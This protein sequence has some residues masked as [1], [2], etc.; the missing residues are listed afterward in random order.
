MN[1]NREITSTVSQA[2]KSDLQLCRLLSRDHIFEEK[3]DDDGLPCI[4]IC[5]SGV[6]D[7]C[8][9]KVCEQEAI[10][11]LQIW[12]RSGE[13]DLAETFMI[14]AQ[15]AL[16]AAGLVNGKHD[17][18]LHPEFSGTRRLPNSRE[19]HGILRYH[20]FHSHPAA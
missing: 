6:Q 7:P 1:A 12:P 3:T 5:E 11:T 18:A 15:H 17:I 19:I 10:V 4:S 8:L 20:A 13:K 9:G 14:S 2:L 16:E